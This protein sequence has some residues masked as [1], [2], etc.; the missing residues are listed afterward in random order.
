MESNHRP[1]INTGAL[2]LSY[3]RIRKTLACA[4]TDTKGFKRSFP[5][6]S[7]RARWIEP[8]SFLLLRKNVLLLN[9][10]PMNWWEGQDSHLQPPGSNARCSKS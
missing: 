1:P 7:G 6:G 3:V 9:Y 8:P 2:T 10:R 4:S 5:N